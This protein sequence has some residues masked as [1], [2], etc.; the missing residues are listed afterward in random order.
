[1]SNWLLLSDIY[2]SPCDEQYTSSTILYLVFERGH[3]VFNIACK[4]LRSVTDVYLLHFITCC[5]PSPFRPLSAGP[6]GIWDTVSQS[7]TRQLQQ[8]VLYNHE[9]MDVTW[10]SMPSM[11]CW[12]LSA[13]WPQMQCGVA[14][15][16]RWPTS[17]LLVFYHSSGEMSW[18][19]TAILSAGAGDLRHHPLWGEHLRPADP[20]R[21]MFCY[22]RILHQLRRLP[23]PGQGH[24]ARR[25][26]V[27][28]YFWVLSTW[29]SSSLPC[30][31]CTSWMDV[32][33][34]TADPRHARP[35]NFL[36]PLLR[37][38][39]Y[40]AF[41][42]EEV[43]SLSTVLF[44]RAGH[45]FVWYRE[46]GLREALEKSSSNH[47]LHAPPPGHSECAGWNSA[48]ITTFLK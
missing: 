38:P 37:E 6:V 48:S 5:C 23:E 7:D 24:Q 44:R 36:H 17:P 10:R 12:G 26:V 32:S 15:C 35:R 29:S 27:P 11:P 19:Y 2:S 33:W 1:M 21:L 45:I 18:C 20:W 22:I 16:P 30:T 40:H 4:K 42:G 9:S 43:Q 47:A 8:H 39:Y 31:T 13:W 46:A 41:M 28:P 25:V 14:D 3:L 34:A